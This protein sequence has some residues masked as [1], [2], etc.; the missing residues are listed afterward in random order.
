MEVAEA[1][2]EDAKNIGLNAK[3]EQEDDQIFVC[4][5]SKAYSD[6]DK[7]IS[8]DEAFNAACSMMRAYADEFAYQMKWVRE[9]L[10]YFEKSFYEHKKG[11]LPSISDAGKMEG[12]LKALGLGDSFR[13]DKPSIR[14]DY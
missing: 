6:S 2:L 10:A 12:A 7:T 8:G 4:Y 3:I 9:D 13:V 14:V 5:E 1:A 11:H